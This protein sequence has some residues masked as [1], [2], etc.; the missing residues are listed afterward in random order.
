MTERGP[1]LVVAAAIVRDSEV[2]LA[3]RH[4]PELPEAHL[5]WEL[6]GG[7]VK[8]E[9]S[10]HDALIREIHEELGAEIQIVRL[11]PHVQSNIYHSQNDVVHSVVLAFESVIVRGAPEPRAA[12]EAVQ[13]VIWV[14]K[15]ELNAFSLLP[16]TQEFVKCL[17]E[18]DRASYSARN[19][20][21]RLER[22]GS[23]GQ[24]LHY[25][26]FQSVCDLWKNFNIIE[27][28]GNLI[29]RS[30]QY[31]V[32]SNIEE[33][34]LVKELRERVRSLASRGYLIVR[35]DNP[36]FIASQI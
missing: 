29:K 32:H 25:R 8:L 7:K 33:A 6:P 27:R 22:R 28:H 36:A 5:K 26:E 23:N 10:P 12:E 14:N 11:L 20:F 30:M 1:T 24:L 4:Q 31:E 34:N 18:P 17:D 2:L 3:R 16:G 19:I 15:S 9:E 35:S 21:I 13:E